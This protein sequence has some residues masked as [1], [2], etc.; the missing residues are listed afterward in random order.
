M[1]VRER[2]IEYY[3]GVEGC[4]FGDWR[5]GITDKKLKNAIDARITRFESGNFGA[6]KS[7]GEGVLESI[8]DYG[9][10]YRIYFGIHGDAVVL[11]CAGDKSTQRRTDIERAKRLWSEHRK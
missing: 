8:I 6:Y 1:E 10:G 7:A 5:D 4:P 9:P 3:D 11:L 2:E